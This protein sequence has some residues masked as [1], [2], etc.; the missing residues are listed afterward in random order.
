MLHHT[1]SINNNQIGYSYKKN[2]QR[3]EIKKEK[4]NEGNQNH[5]Q[6]KKKNKKINNVLSLLLNKGVRNNKLNFC[7]I[8]FNI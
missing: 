6:S 7:C 2:T 4:Q 3:V 5:D 8:I 1:A